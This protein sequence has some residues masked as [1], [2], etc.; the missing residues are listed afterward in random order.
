MKSLVNPKQINKKQFF[1]P[2]P[3]NKSKKY[4]PHQPTMGAPRFRPASGNFSTKGGVLVRRQLTLLT[5]E[6]FSIESS[7]LIKA[8]DERRG[9]IFESSY[10]Y[11]GRYARWTMGFV[12]PPLA[13]E[14]RG[15]NFNIQALNNRGAVLLPAIHDCLS[16]CTD[17]QEIQ[18]EKGKHVV[19]TV[20]Q[21]PAGTRFPEEQRSKQPS[22]FSIV[23]S[24]IELFGI[25]PS[26]DPQLG[27]YGSFGYDLT[28]QFEQVKEHHQR[29]L[30]SNGV[31]IQRDLLLYLPDSIIVLDGQAK[32]AYRMDY[33]FSWDTLTTRGMPRVGAS[34]PFH[35]VVE[36]EKRRDHEPG[37]YAKKVEKAREEFRVGNLFE[38]VLSQVFYEPCAAPPS[39]IFGK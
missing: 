23:R 4:H 30:D 35:G 11:P 10:E 7:N 22:I 37:E 18:M 5:P 20:R 31:P 8:L 1:P 33:D 15:R 38:C 3:S 16:R 12:D 13:F 21:L 27:L 9:C 28:F 14:G 32:D 19:G 34:V 25:D 26:V 6:E 24:I 39:E 29:E 36:L 2:S 17:V